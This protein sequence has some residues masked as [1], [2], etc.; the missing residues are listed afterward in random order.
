MFNIADIRSLEI[1]R[2]PDGM[3][4]RIG[5]ATTRTILPYF[6]R[7]GK[8]MGYDDILSVQSVEKT[9]WNIH[10]DK[11][12]TA[13]PTGWK[14]YQGKVK[15]MW[16]RPVVKTVAIATAAATVYNMVVLIIKAI[17]P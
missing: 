14:R 2:T 16:K 1:V 8:M 10:P 6:L 17:I 3:S 11:N 15:E 4:K 9:G 5:Y 13:G 7:R 12:T